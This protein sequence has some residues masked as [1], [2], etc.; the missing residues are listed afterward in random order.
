MM[1][2]DELQSVTP[3]KLA[4][5]T[6]KR[7]GQFCHLTTDEPVEAL[8]EF[9]RRLGLRRGWFQS[10]A[11]VPHYDLTPA[12]RAKALELG[13]TFVPARKQAEWRI[14]ERERARIASVE[15]ANAPE[16]HGAAQLS[17]HNP[18]DSERV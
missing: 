7:V 14:T 17:Q 1:M 2:V 9:A 12:R 15:A 16:S 13:A 18:G 11:A 6:F 10:A 3:F 4:P 8:H 5:K